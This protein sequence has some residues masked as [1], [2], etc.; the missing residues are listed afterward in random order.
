MVAVLA[1][2]TASDRAVAETLEGLGVDVQNK[3]D[4]LRS[5]QIARGMFSTEGDVN[6]FSPD[7]PIKGNAVKTFPRDLFFVLRVVQLLRGLKAAMG[8]DVRDFS[9]ARRWRHLARRKA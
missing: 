3:H 5:A 7:S 4:H 1:D 9:S 6:P 2:P 8:E